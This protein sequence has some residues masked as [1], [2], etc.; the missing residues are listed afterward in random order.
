MRR[1]VW[2][3]GRGDARAIHQP[4]R[5]SFEEQG[6]GGYLKVFVLRLLDPRVWPRDPRVEA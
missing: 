5:D 4:T 6:T 2:A 1:A 3:K